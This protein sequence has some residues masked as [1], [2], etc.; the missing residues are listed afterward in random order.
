M[1]S[2][3][4]VSAVRA[5]RRQFQTHI[6]S[7]HVLKKEESP[8]MKRPRSLSAL[9]PAYLQHIT[10][11]TKL[12]GRPSERVTTQAAMAYC[13]SLLQ[14]MEHEKSPRILCV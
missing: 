13:S 4:Y 8:R 14:I 10:Y 6:V 7:H 3:W 9:L 11:D 5:A 1:R 12:T 2:T